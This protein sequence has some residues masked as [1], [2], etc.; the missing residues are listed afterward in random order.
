MGEKD[1]MK[2]VGLAGCDLD[3]DDAKT[4]VDYVRDSASLTECNVRGNNLDAESATLLAKV[5][6]EK[7]ITLC[8]MK[9]D[10]TEANFAQQRLGPVDAI[11]IASD[12]LVCSS[13]TV[14]ILNY[15]YIS[16][17]DGGAIAIGHAL[18]D[19]AK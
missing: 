16:I 14:L 3:V 7:R 11:L 4:V 13:L 1:Q 15:N 8:G 2:S 12:L 10:Q 6:T 19:N 17:G 9:H 18:R 5:G